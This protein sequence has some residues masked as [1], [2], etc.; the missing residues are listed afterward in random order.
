[1]YLCIVNGCFRMFLMEEHRTNIYYSW[2]SVQSC[3]I[4]L[5]LGN[6]MERVE[7]QRESAWWAVAPIPLGCV[8]RNTSSDPPMIAGWQTVTHTHT[9][10]FIYIYIDGYYT[11]YTHI[12]IY[13][14][15]CLWGC[16]KLINPEK[17]GAIQILWASDSATLGRNPHD[18]M[19]TTGDFV[20][21][22]IQES[23]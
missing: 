23:T 7:S 2:S 11:H 6:M 15:V 14:C 12:Y 19:V 22:A 17:G 20:P 9:Y 18:F 4:E 16:W 3:L 13:I 8:N 10:L 21:L 5:K 1:M